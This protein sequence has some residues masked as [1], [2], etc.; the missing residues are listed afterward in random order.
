MGWGAAF[1][2]SVFLR[3][4]FITGGDPASCSPIKKTLVRWSTWLT[5]RVCLLGFN[6]LWND[7]TI[8]EISYKKY[9]GP[10][11]KPEYDGAGSIVTNHQSWMD[12]LVLMCYQPPSFVAKGS[13]RDVPFVGKIA[14]ICGCLFF[15]RSSKEER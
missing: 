9:L 3:L 7:T 4:L 2:N 14:E 13:V 5:G 15:D 6:V 10:D 8:P 1:S 11:W 12:I